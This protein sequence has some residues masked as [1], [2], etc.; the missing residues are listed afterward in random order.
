[1]NNLLDKVSSG[2]KVFD[3]E[4]DEIG[5]VE[6]VQAGG[7]TLAQA[8]TTDLSGADQND[9]INWIAHAFTTDSVPE[10]LRERLLSQGFIRIDADGL[11]ASD[12]YLL[13]DQIAAVATGRVDLNVRKA[14]LIKLK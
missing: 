10:E 7:E 3:V 8:G 6:R 14:D 4:G 2:M 12:R 1:M 11:F 5:E 13:P 9:P